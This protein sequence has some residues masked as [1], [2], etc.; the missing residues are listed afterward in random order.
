MTLNFT[1]YRNMIQ[2]VVAAGQTYKVN[3]LQNG[4]RIQ[5][6]LSDV[7]MKMQNFYCHIRPLVNEKDLQEAYAELVVD[8]KYLVLEIYN[9]K[10]EGRVYPK[11]LLRS[12]SNGF[13]FEAEEAKEMTFAE[14]CEKYSQYTLSDKL[15]MNV[16]TRYSMMR[17]VIYQCNGVKLA[18]CVSPITTGV[19]YI[20]AK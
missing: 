8:G 13:I 15:I 2:E 9:Y 11:K 6:G 5:L 4:Q 1:N 16:H 7:Y 14:F 19:K 17:E 12:L 20:T 3:E 18:C 10:G